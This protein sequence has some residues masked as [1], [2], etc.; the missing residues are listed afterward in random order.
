MNPVYESINR[1]DL[2][3][4]LAAVQAQVRQSPAEPKH[5]VLLFQLLAVVG[6]WSRALDQLAVLQQISPTMSPLVQTY[7]SAI[8]CEVFRASV[9]QGKHTPLFLGQPAEW[10]A[11]LVQ[12]LQMIALGKHQQAVDLR[13]KAFEAAPA[14]AGTIDGT[15]FPWLADA[16]SRLGPILEALVN[17]K[18]YWIPLCNLSSIQIEKPTDLRDFV[19]IP[20]T[21]SLVNGGETVA[22]LPVRYP[23]SETSADSAIRLARK[24]E[25]IGQDPDPVLGL[26]QRMLA[27]DR[28]EYP[29]LDARSIKLSPSA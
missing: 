22:L 20:A 24:T 29:L 10:T 13:A 16:D 17:G 14:T 11:L 5:H 15:E 1:G 8:E 7:R 19:W 25:W 27:T 12:A 26:G 9:F 18:Y 4:A 6:Q 3:A 28:N 2:D 23:G 21:L